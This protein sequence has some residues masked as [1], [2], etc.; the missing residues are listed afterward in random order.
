MI[1]L[2]CTQ[3]LRHPNTVCIKDAIAKYPNK[4]NI[5]VSKNRQHSIDVWH[6]CI[7]QKN[8]HRKGQGSSPSVSTFFFVIRFLNH[9]FLSLTFP[10]SLSDF[11]I[12]LLSKNLISLCIGKF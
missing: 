3:C 12:E 4:E 9:I 1:F 2:Q 11:T 10:I 5:L 6:I 7:R 8:L